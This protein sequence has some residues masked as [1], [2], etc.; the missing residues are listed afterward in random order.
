MTGARIAAIEHRL[1]V[2][3][4]NHKELKEDFR[5]FIKLNEAHH[6]ETTKTLTETNL[7]LAVIS[8]RLGGAA[9][10]F[11][12]IIAS[13]IVSGVGV[14]AAIILKFGGNG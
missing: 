3:E 9:R 10:V 11:W 5:E 7:K 12:L 4:S 8:T 14:V 1:D 2:A 13:V 6:R